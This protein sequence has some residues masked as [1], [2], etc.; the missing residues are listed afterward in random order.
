MD[1][2]L[3]P[4][5][6]TDVK[7][8]REIIYEYLRQAIL[9]GGVKPGERLVERDIAEKLSASR[10]PV[11]EALRKLESEGFVTYLPRKGMVVKGVNMDEIDE[12][13]SIR[14]EL[15]CL[16]IRHAIKNISEEQLLELRELVAALELQ[17]KS[18]A[19]QATAMKLHD[20]D[21]LILNAA[22]MPTLTGFL[23]SMYD[24]LKRYKCINLS[25]LP[26]RKE[27]VREHKEI[28][29]AIIDRD[30]KRAE[31]LVRLHVEHS[32]NELRKR[33]RETDLPNLA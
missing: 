11:R 30:G 32:R 24:T 5:G 9:D 16:A 13:Y 6:L 15:E 22:G 10:T 18:D 29:Q 21:D 20:F 26:R 2:L 12:I 7:P 23:H 8:I 25:N 19:T 4:A 3:V 28:L 31:Q 14:T 27:A 1:E 17:A 33:M